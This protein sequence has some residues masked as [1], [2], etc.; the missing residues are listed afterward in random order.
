M[1]LDKNIFLMGEEVAEYDGAYKVSKGMFK[2]FVH[3]SHRLS[4]FRRWVCWSW[5][6]SSHEWTKPIIEMMT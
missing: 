4:Y 2:E 6:W 1:R 5:H 3:A